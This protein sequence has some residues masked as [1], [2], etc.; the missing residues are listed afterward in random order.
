MAR[1]TSLFLAALAASRVAYAQEPGTFKVAGKTLVSAMMFLGNDEKVYILDKSENNAAQINGHPA[2]GVVWDIASNTAEVM[3][4]VSNA[5]CAAGFQMPNGTWAAFGG[6][7]AVQPSTTQPSG[8]EDYNGNGVAPGYGD[9]DGRRAV[10]LLQPCTGP[11]DSFGPECTW[12]DNAAVLSMARSRWYATAEAL[13]DGSVALIGGMVNGGYIN[14]DARWFTL[15]A[16]RDP[17]TQ[18]RQ[19]ENTIEFFPARPGFQPS[20]SQFLVNAGGLNTYAHTYLLKSGKMFLQA[21]VSTILLDTDTMTETPLPDMPNGIIRVYPASGGTTMLPLTPENNWNPTI[22]FCGGTSAFSDE[23]WGTYAGPNSNPWESDAS[24]DCQRITPEPEDGT[25]AAY[26][27]DDDMPDART[28]G[29]FIQLPDGKLLML[30]GARKGTAGYATSTPSI[31]SLDQMPFYMSLATD[32]VLTPAIYD[33]S[34]P[35]GQRWSSEGLGAS[36]IPRLYHSTAV[37][38]PDGSVMIAGSNPG[39]DV[40]QQSDK[41]PYA[42]SYDAEI[43][44]PPY[45]GK[46]RPVPSGIPTTP[47]TYGGPYFN[48]TIAA[49][50]LSG[51]PNELAAKTKVALVRTGFSTHGMQMG[52]RYVQLQSTYTVADDGSIALHVAPPPPNAN[53]LT[54]G[55]ALMYVV[56]DGVPSIG[57][58]VMIGSGQVG[59]QQLTMPVALPAN[60]LSKKFAGSGDNTSAGGNGNGNSQSDQQSGATSTTKKNGL[61]TGAIVGIIIAVLAVLAFLVLIA[62]MATRQ[63]RKY[64]ERWV[65]SGSAAA[66]QGMRQPPGRGMVAAAKTNSNG[67]LNISRPLLQPQLGANPFADSAAAGPIPS[68][69]PSPVPGPSS[70]PMGPPPHMLMGVPPSHTSHSRHSSE[71]NPI[72]SGYAPQPMMETSPFAAPAHTRTLSNGSFR[73]NP[74]SVQFGEAHG[75]PSGSQYTQPNQYY[76]QGPVRY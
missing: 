27:Q 40:T 49:D 9:M 72:G 23:E 13:G 60:H 2:M 18:Q 12:F 75:Y 17:A 70:M 20:Q 14:R 67:S 56:V 66:A 76:D 38:L 1:T 34:A 50:S 15:P 33:P 37:L 61:S 32:P 28:M 24:A 53:I 57:K 22:L 47:L 29:Q 46:Q 64:H 51:N 74:G 11:A 39:A 58:H 54:P 35:A 25:Q 62:I 42:T 63:K 43:F 71:V 52:Q 45:F 59:E 7:H 44:Y 69:T 30:N 31:R 55:P 5:F 4:V 26:L 65:S 73:P 16:T 8:V 6:N 10:R 21:N 48:M 19:A 41:I 3:D 68:R 36:Q